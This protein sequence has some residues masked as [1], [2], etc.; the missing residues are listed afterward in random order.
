MKTIGTKTS[1]MRSARRWIG[2][3]RALGPLD[4]LDDPG[5]GRVAA[6]PRG[7]HDERAGGVE[8]RADD[9]VTGPCRDRD[10]LAGQHR[11]VD[12]GAALDD[13]RRRPGPCRRAGRGGGRRRATGLERDVAPRRRATS[14]PWRG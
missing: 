9:R 10:R 11:L 6:D 3:L 5:Q 8:R 14:A 4:E 2:A 1:A 13:E 12:R 7:A